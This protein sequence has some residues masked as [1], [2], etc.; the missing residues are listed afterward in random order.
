MRAEEEDEEE[1]GLDL[2]TSILESAN[3]A[4]ASLADLP[5]E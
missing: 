1:E 3:L 5:L 2:V 4:I